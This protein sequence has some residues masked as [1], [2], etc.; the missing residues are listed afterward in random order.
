MIHFIRI[1]KNASR[2]IKSTNLFTCSNH[3]PVTQLSE[4]FKDTWRTDIKFCVTRNPYDR[5]VSA[6]C[7][8]IEFC[9]KQQRPY[10]PQFKNFTSF[11]EFCLDANNLFFFGEVRPAGKR[12]VRVVHPHFRTQC[13]WV[14]NKDDKLDI[15]FMM[16]FETLERDWITFLDHYKIP[17][18]SLPQRNSSEHERWKNY[19]TKRIAD[20]VYSIYEE[21]FRRLGYSRD[22]WEK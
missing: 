22:S 8:G 20:V 15:N 21:D 16:R 14:K 4:K 11:E 9:E 1:P 12:S 18:T 2:S 5:L 17:W 19:Y 3:I 10:F 6:Y 7:N 13:Y